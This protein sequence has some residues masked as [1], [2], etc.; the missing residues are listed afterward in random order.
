MAAVAV[1]SSTGP[2]SRVDISGSVIRNC[3]GAGVRADTEFGTVNRLDGSVV[4]GCGTPLEVHLTGLSGVTQRNDFSGN[5]SD[6]IYLPQV[7]IDSDMQ[8]VNL[9]VPYVSA[10][11]RV[12]DGNLKILHG[13]EIQFS[14]QANFAVSG[15]ILVEGREDSRVKLTGTA[16]ERGH[17]GVLS[18]NGSAIFEHVDIEFGGHGAGSVFA[19]AI[20][21]IGQGAVS[22]SHVSISQSSLYAIHMSN[23]GGRITKMDSVELSGNNKTIRMGL[24]QLNQLSDQLM[25]L[26]NDS[27][28]IELTTTDATNLDV[29][30]LNL[31]VPYLVSSPVRLENGSIRIRPGVTVFMGDGVG[32]DVSNTASFSAVGT[33]EEP[34]TLT[35]Q[36]QLPGA[37]S[38]ITVSSNSNLNRIEH[39]NI[40]FAGGAIGGIGSAVKLECN[41]QAML[42]VANTTIEDSAGWGIV[43][44]NVDGCALAIGDNVQFNRNRSGDIGIE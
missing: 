29:D 1:S 39:T 37:W 36:A 6:T 24:S 30:L 14:T 35:H 43:S 41:P 42:F 19:P 38:G 9:G 40:A 33:V 5:E 4:S 21:R 26:S 8:L 3:L 32:V 44:D 27:S 22:L 13:V 28:A 25:I 10:G 15:S 12:A 7:T 16:K 17:W 11:I 2:L 20:L 18:V 31:G 34:I 23:P